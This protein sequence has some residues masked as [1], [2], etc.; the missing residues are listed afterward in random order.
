[1][2]K[3]NLLKLRLYEPNKKYFEKRQSEILPGILKNGQK[4]AYELAR[5]RFMMKCYSIFQESLV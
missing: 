2:K 5:G 4:K 1:M 3:R